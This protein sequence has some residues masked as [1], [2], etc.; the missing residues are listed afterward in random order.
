MEMGGTG[1]AALIESTTATAS[2]LQVGQRNS[3]PL[4]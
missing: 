3:D 2:R 4:I 1:E